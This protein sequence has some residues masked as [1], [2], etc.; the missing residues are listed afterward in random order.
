MTLWE[1]GAGLTVQKG[2][3]KLKQSDKP[4]LRKIP[5]KGGGVAGGG[6][7][8]AG[9]GNWFNQMNPQVIRAA[10]YPLAPSQYALLVGPAEP[11]TIFKKRNVRG[12]VTAPVVGQPLSANYT[13]S[14]PSAPSGSGF[15]QA[16]SNE[17]GENIPQQG[18][19]PRINER[20]NLP[21]PSP[22][23]MQGVIPEAPNPIVASAPPPPPPPPVFQV[24]QNPVV[25]PRIPKKEKTPAEIEREAKNKQQG[26]LASELA[27]RLKSGSTGLKK[28][29]RV[30]AERATRMDKIIKEGYVTEEDRQLQPLNAQHVGDPRDAAIASLRNNLDYLVQHG[31]NEGKRGNNLEGELNRIRQTLDSTKQ[32]AYEK[33]Q[34]LAFQ[35]AEVNSNLAKTILQGQQMQQTHAQEKQQMR[36]ERDERIRELEIEYEKKVDQLNSANNSIEEREQRLAAASNERDLRIRELEAEYDNQVDEIDM[37][38]HVIDSRDNLKLDNTTRPNPPSTGNLLQQAQVDTRPNVV[39]SRDAVNKLRDSRAEQRG[40][41]LAGPRRSTNVLLQGGRRSKRDSGARKTRLKGHNYD[42]YG[43]KNFNGNSI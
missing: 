29:N 30:L 43:Q 20:S 12:N 2:P 25:L 37:L 7:L 17:E 24:A 6:T 39:R 18:N 21:S 19:E 5:W 40:V 9:H 27:A 32:G 35:I 22:S 11:S 28:S 41:A 33:E 10:P 3:F 38:H 1:Q 8:H 4:T 13:A 15:Q 36:D 34:N 16:L 31:V 23:P 14:S 26:D 42:Y